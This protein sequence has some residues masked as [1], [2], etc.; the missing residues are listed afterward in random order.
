MKLADLEHRATITVDEAASL[1]GI[2]RNTAYEAIRAGQIPALRLGRRLLVPVPALLRMLEG[3][4]APFDEG[5][6]A[7]GSSPDGA[8]EDRS[9]GHRAYADP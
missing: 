7:N 3:A 5:G 9:V 6:S 4:E 8:A 2:G 1:L